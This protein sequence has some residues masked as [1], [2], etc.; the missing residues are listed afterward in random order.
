MGVGGASQLPLGKGVPRGGA[1]GLQRLFNRTF[2]GHSVCG[3]SV[4]HSPVGR[5][6]GSARTLGRA[7]EC[8]REPQG[9]LGSFVQKEGEEKL[10]PAGSG[11]STVIRL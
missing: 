9:C 5:A 1:A 2:P 6:T 10:G 8:P 4:K 3:W 11:A 7:A